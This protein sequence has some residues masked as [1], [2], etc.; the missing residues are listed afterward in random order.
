[1]T[2]D[3]ERLVVELDKTQFDRLRDDLHEWDRICGETRET[4][5]RY[6]PFSGLITGY[7]LELDIGE[8]D[9]IVLYQLR[10]G[11]EF[12]SAEFR[13][14]RRRQPRPDLRQYY[15]E[16]KPD[17]LRDHLDAPVILFFQDGRIEERFGTAE[18]K[19]MDFLERMERECP[20]IEEAGEIFL[21]TV[22][23]KPMNF[24]KRSRVL[25]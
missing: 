14:Y 5:F 7:K 10:D 24:S 3:A 25:T 4:F 17:Y 19:E 13:E 23:L 9:A 15:L 20:A 1:M 6:E 16:R 12:E 2:S 22:R 8:Y 21:G 11:V 18:E